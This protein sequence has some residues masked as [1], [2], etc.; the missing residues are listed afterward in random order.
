MDLMSEFL[1]GGSQLAVSFVLICLASGWT[2]VQ[3]EDDAV[4]AN[5]VGSLLRH[6]GNMVKGANKLVFIVI[7]LVVGTTTLQLINKLGD[8]DFTK[9]H[10]YESRAG[11]MLV[12]VHLFLGTAFVG[13]LLATLRAQSKR[14]SEKLTVFLRRLLLLG[15]LW[16]LVFPVCV[17]FA[18]TLA[19]YNRHRFVSGSVLIVQTICLS[20]MFYQFT[21]SHSTYFKLSTL[22][23]VGVLP[24]AGGFVKPQKLSKD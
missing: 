7:G 9:F 15:G 6:P 3:Y 1:D 13:S 18:G 24:G 22:A 2:L 16:F 20:M 17:F 23:E 5:S 11:F 19:H 21:S 8:D 14:G 4:R 10:D 12:G